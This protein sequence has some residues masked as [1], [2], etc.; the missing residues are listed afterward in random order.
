MFIVWGHDL[1]NQQRDIEHHPVRLLKRTF[2]HQHIG[3]TIARFPDPG[4]A[5]R[6][7]RNMERF[8]ESG[9]MNDQDLLE[10][11]VAGGSQIAL[12]NHPVEIFTITIGVAGRKILI[13]GNEGADLA[14]V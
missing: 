2:H 13:D 10:G 14:L 5:F 6:T 3:N 11:A 4:A 7:N 9:Q 8:F 1:H 12:H